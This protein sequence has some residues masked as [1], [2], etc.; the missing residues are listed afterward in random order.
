MLK[1]NKNPIRKQLEQHRKKYIARHPMGHQILDMHHPDDF[2]LVSVKGSGKGTTRAEAEKE[3][4]D[5]EAQTVGTQA[6]RKREGGE[7]REKGRRGRG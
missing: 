1:Y 7:G 3:G 6:E 4:M 5:K 2:L